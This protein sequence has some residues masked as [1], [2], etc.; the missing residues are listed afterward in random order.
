MLALEV[1]GASITNPTLFCGS[2]LAGA[3]SGTT[4]RLHRWQ[5]SSH[6]CTYALRHTAPCGSRLAGDGCYAFMQAQPGIC[7]AGKPAPT[8]APTPCA[9]PLLWEPACRR[10]LIRV[11]AGTTRRLHRWQASSHKCTYAL[12][13]SA[14]VGAG[15]P[16]MAATRSCRHKGSSASLAS[17]L[18]QV[19]PHPAPHRP[20]WESACR[21]WLLRV[22]A[23]T[24]RRLYRW[25]ASSHKCTHTLHHPAPV[26]TGLPAMAATRSCRHKGCLH[27]WQASSHKC[28]HTVRHSASV[29]A[30]LPAMTATRSCRHNRASASLASQLSQVHPHPAPPR[31]CGSRLAGDGWYAF[32]QAQPGVCI[33]G[34][35]APT[36]A[37]TP[38]ATLPLWE[39]ACRR[40]L[41][42]VPADTTRRLHRWQA[43]SHKQTSTAT[44]IL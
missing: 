13:H 38:C 41:L 33:A 34:K 35:P 42:C 8:S 5:A 23:G 18:P 26:G 43:S 9:T 27:R 36:S 30:G 7:I 44:L 40:W 3:A 16:A 10:W 12:H 20:L 32:L 21:R 24:T 14:P 29:G 39:P 15:L 28:T 19:H 6:K 11:P 17:Q 1:E 22:P 4:G 2:R 37:P 31:L 25:Q